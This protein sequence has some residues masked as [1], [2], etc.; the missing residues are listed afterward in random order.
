MHPAASTARRPWRWPLGWLFGLGF[1]LG[2]A[3]W[4]GFAWLW[5]HWSTIDHGHYAWI[6]TVMQLE[7]PYRL[8]LA[9][10][11]LGGLGLVMT[12]N[13]L[14]RRAWKRALWWLLLA[15]LAAGHCTASLL[16]MVVAMGGGVTPDVPQ[17]DIVPGK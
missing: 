15:G 5:L 16:P 13:N 17:E 9:V 12:I 1:A 8:W 2:L 7:L 6:L 3:S 10:A 11:A 14:I 4:G